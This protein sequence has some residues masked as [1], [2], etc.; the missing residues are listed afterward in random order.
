MHVGVEVYE[1]TPASALGGVSAGLGRMTGLLRAGGVADEAIMTNEVVV[2]P[3]WDHGLPPEPYTR[4]WGS[5]GLTVRLTHEQ[6]EGGLLHDLLDSPE[7]R[8][9]S[10]VLRTVDRGVAYG[11]AL[12]RAFEDAHAKAAR[13]AEL[14]EARLGAVQTLTEGSVASRPSPYAL[15]PSSAPGGPSSGGGLLEGGGHELTATLTVTW[16]LEDA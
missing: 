9:H 15:D 4:L 3:H 13:L 14:S 1:D 6:A 10:L 2:R 5:G 11:R 16:Q 8:L 7:A 12:Q